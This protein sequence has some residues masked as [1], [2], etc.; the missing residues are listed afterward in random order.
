[1]AA[2]A[3]AR[4]AWTIAWLGGAVIGIANGAA[5]ELLYRDRVGELAAHQISTAT[6]LALFA[7]SFRALDRRWPLASDREA[8][9]VGGRWLAL[10]VCFEFGFGRAVDRRSWAELLRDYDLRAGR[11]WTLVLAWLALGPLA[12]RRLRVRRG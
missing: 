10:T 2:G 1:V 6:G 7:A 12:T 11:V 3:P 4:R 9:A 8:L 5:R